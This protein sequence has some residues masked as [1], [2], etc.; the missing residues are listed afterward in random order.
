MSG[1]SSRE[2]TAYHEAGHAVV[3]YLLG[4]QLGPV[5]IIPSAQFAGATGLTGYTREVSSDALEGALIKFKNSVKILLAGYWAQRMY[6]PRSLRKAH[7]MDD[8]AA[9][10]QFVSAIE[11]KPFEINSLPFLAEQHLEVRKMLS[12]NWLLVEEFALYLLEQ[13]EISGQQAHEFLTRAHKI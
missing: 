6:N 13:R 2:A 10:G 5:T 1:R 8:N 11:G 3:A 9:I 12:A 7:S 4:V